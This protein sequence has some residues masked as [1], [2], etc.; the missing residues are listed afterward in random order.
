MRAAAPAT[1][2]TATSALLILQTDMVHACWSI[3][4][5][6]GCCLLLSDAL[7]Q[8]G[9]HLT[10][11]FGIPVRTCAVHRMFAENIGI[12]YKTPEEVFG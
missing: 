9:Q 2:P 6:R 7:P 11:S 12:A 1:L 5:C 4:P 8:S 10:L 3:R